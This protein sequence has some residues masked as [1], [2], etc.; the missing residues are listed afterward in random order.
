MINNASQSLAQNSK[1][2]MS[3]YVDAAEE[4]GDDHRS[5]LAFRNPVQNSISRFESVRG[6]VSER[7]ES[8]NIIF[9]G[10]DVVVEATK[11]DGTV[12]RT[13]RSATFADRM[14]GC[15]ILLVWA[16]LTFGFLAAMGFI[17]FLF[18]RVFEFNPFLGFA[19]MLVCCCVCSG[20]PTSLPTAERINERALRYGA[21][22]PIAEE[23]PAGTTTIAVAQ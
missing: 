3:S 7:I 15:S 6:I 23:N 16:L 12:E 8:Q 11:A 21:I 14:A 4:G 2:T 18:F 17:I 1:T 22:P 13:I 10:D 19:T 20:S 9:R 5:S